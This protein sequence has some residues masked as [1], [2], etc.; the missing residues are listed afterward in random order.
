MK[1]K[2]DNKKQQQKE[3]ES[4]DNEDLELF[5]REGPRPNLEKSVEIVR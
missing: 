5:S 4:R 2:K 3:E 1:Q